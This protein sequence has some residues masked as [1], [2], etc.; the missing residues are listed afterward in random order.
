MK[1]SLVYAEQLCFA[2]FMMFLSSFKKACSNQVKSRGL[3]DNIHKISLLVVWKIQ[4]EMI[5]SMLF[6]KATGK[7]IL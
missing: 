6:K 5:F 2:T 7:Y 4:R 3:N 1:L